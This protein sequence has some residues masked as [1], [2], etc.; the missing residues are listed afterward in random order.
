MLKSIA[1]MAALAVLGIVGC[2][3]SPGGGSS[4][5]GGGTGT[6]SGGTEPYYG[7]FNLTAV[8]EG[9]TPVFT[10]IAGFYAD[11]G[12]PASSC[13]G[14]Q[15][16]SC[17]Y[18]PAGTKSTTPTPVSAGT[19]TLTDK[20]ASIG[21]LTFD[22]SSATGYAPIS[23]LT[24]S[25]LSW[26][27]GDTVSV[28]ATGATVEAFS[29]SAIA[30]PNIAGLNPMPSETSP[31]TVTDASGLTVTWTAG[32]GDSSLF[33]ALDD[34]SINVIT[35]EVPITAGT[36]SVPSSLLTHLSGTGS[37]GIHAQSASSFNGP[38]ANLAILMIGDDINGLA[39]FQ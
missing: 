22:A 26:S 25:G 36:L 5:T 31:F 21:Q 8:T 23:S 17:C 24:T 4:G 32:S 15:S 28:S 33:L 30:P 37:I 29:G 3:S 18:I 34:A 27:P 9:T 39:T 16:G 20:G 12:A 7:T 10:A 6:G 14:T 38:N 13:P 19:L 2:S 35:C 11:T 1:A